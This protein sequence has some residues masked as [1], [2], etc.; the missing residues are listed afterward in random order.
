MR[1]V[2]WHGAIAV[3]LTV[4]TQVGGLAWLLALRSRWRLPAFVAIYTAF[5][6]A[7]LWL[8]P[9][10]GRMPLTCGGDGP[11]RVQG[12]SSAPRTGTTSCPNWRPSCPTLRAGWTTPS[13]AR[14]L[15]LD[16]GFPVLTGFPL[17]PHLSH[18]DGRKAD[19]AFYYADADG[20]LPGRTRSPVG[21]FAF[22]PGPSNCPPGVPH[23]ALVASDA[24]T[25]LA[26]LAAGQG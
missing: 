15:V 8:A 16:A 3:A 21:Y 23:V 4:M 20:Y 13:P 18:E 5:T 14:T 2:A 7:A 6:V 1:R 12:S 24:A 19:I 17:I 11:L 26:R 9:L 10:A 25:P 22:T